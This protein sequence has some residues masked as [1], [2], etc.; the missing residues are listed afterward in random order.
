MCAAFVVSL[1]AGWAVSEA[2]EH[3]DQFSLDRSPAE[4]PFFY[5]S[6]FSVLVL[7]GAILFSGINIVE[8][9]IFVELLDSLLL[10][11][12]VGF[13]FLLSS[14]E[15]L[16]P[17]VRLCGWYRDI[18]RIVFSVVAFTGVFC[19]IHGLVM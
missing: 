2:L 17:E 3:D 5:G 1:A 8:L 10:P 15:M 18:L 12:A 7:G 11:F 19:A 13:V 14:S 6:F 9:N 16:P 4:A